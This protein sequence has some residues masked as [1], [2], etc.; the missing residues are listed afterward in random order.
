MNKY[1]FNHQGILSY[2]ED[3]EFKFYICS[4]TRKENGIVNWIGNV[5]G[6][7][8]WEV[9]AKMIIKIYGEVKR[10]KENAKK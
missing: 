4:C 6:K 7:T 2:F 1:G 8:M 3:G 10:E 9:F 5:Y